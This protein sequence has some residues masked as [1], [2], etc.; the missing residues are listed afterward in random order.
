MPVMAMAMAGNTPLSGQKPRYSPG[1]RALSSR[2]VNSV[3]LAHTPAS[4][5]EKNAKPVRAF[6]DA[7]AD[8]PF[9][10][11][12]VGWIQRA[13]L[14]GITPEARAVLQSPG[15]AGASPASSSGSPALE[16][17][18]ASDTAPAPRL[19]TDEILIEQ[20]VA[21]TLRDFAA[22]VQ[23][24]GNTPG[25][26]PASPLGTP[27]AA[28]T[29]RGLARLLPTV[30]ASGGFD[31]ATPVERILAPNS[32][33]L[34]ESELACDAQPAAQ[35]APAHS[36]ALGPPAA[37]SDSLPRYSCTLLGFREVCTQE[38]LR[39]AAFPQS[40]ILFTIEVAL[41]DSGLGCAK[42]GVAERRFSEFVK[43]DAELREWM[44]SEHLGCSTARWAP[45]LPPKRLWPT[46]A[47]VSAERQG[48]LQ[49]YLDWVM[50]LEAEA[51][52]RILL[53]WLLPYL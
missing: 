33:Q 52:R 15:A 16:W 51:P 36:A 12:A 40:F 43:L 3:W 20:A 37:R 44:Q 23:D 2:S 45:S 14:S 24:A 38:P 30:S 26:A 8:S 48:A 1:R 7:V 41:P 17:K 47:S 34:S 32:P 10:S 49:C 25:P 13:V 42:L 11:P 31:V 21:S 19:K 35:L 4:G 9:A 22:T 28:A 46:R 6:S 39:P 5:K 27:V 50:T 29:Q 53:K 18:I